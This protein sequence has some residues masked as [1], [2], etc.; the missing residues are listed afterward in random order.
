MTRKRTKAAEWKAGAPPALDMSTLER[1]SA[2]C[3]ESVRTLQACVARLT[4]KIK[5]SPEYDR[6]AV[7][8][9]AWLNAQITSI[10]GELRQQEKARKKDIAS[11]SDDEVVD[12]VRGLPERRRDAIVIAVQGAS[13]AGKPLF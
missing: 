10:M 5:S 6:E 1:A 4:A 2:A 12:Y 11:F 7:S 9:L 8:H 13:L 3:D